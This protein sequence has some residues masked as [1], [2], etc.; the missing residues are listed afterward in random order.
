ME[1]ARE[2]GKERRDR[3]MERSDNKLV[4]MWVGKGNQGKKKVMGG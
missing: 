3:A 2:K 1:K 4:R